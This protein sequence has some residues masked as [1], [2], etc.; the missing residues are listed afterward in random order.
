MAIDADLLRHSVTASDAGDYRSGGFSFVL[1]F[2][3]P[4]NVGGLPPEPPPYWSFQR[5]A[6]LRATILKEAFWSSAVTIAAT[7][8]ATAGFDLDGPER[9]TR[10][11]QEMILEWSGSGEGY[12]PSQQRAV[13]DYLTTGNGT[14]FEIVR[15]S[16]AAGSKIIG[17]ITL[18]SLRC[19]RT[20]DP[21]VPILYRDLKGN[22]HEM[23]DYQVVSI[24]DQPDS[25][26]AWFGVGHCAAERAYTH[27]YRMAA[28]EQYIAE[29]I[30]GSGATKIALVQG[31]S[32]LQIDN[33]TTT[34][35]AQKSSKGLTYY[36]G[37]IIAGIL[38]DTPIDIKEIALR[39]LPDGFN[40]KEE[41]DI[42]LLAYADA[43]GLDPQDLQPLSGQ[44]LGTG[45][46]TR[47]LH[48]KAKGRWPARYNKQFA[49]LL[50]MWVT[51]DSVTF[52]FS[53][54]DLDDDK[55][56]V[57]NAATRAGTLEKYINAGVINP[58]QALQIAVDADDVPKEFLPQDV[59]P[60]E[61][62]SDVEKPAIDSVTDGTEVPV[63]E[64]PAP[65]A[66]PM[67]L[68]SLDA[69]Y[70]LYQQM[71][72]ELG[73]ASSQNGETIKAVTEPE[74]VS[75]VNVSVTMPSITLSP[76]MAFNLPEQKAMESNI[77]FEPQH[78]TVNIPPQQSLDVSS[79]ADALR[80]QQPP[81]INNTIQV[82]ALDTTPIADA[83]RD[84]K[85][86]SV[87]VEGANITV[88]VPPPKPVTRRVVRDRDGLISEVIEEMN[89]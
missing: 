74:P 71:R 17:L 82:A 9:Q 16:S 85:P 58:S 5:D 40:R 44:G 21:D 72:K 51:P 52:S 50:N 48:E 36:M 47:V 28:I 23:R 78:I 69:G 39:G 81:I 89:G 75:P 43:I 3:F 7:K 63:I 41:L 24:V 56:E 76:Q 11:Y 87:T 53:E 83:L 15:V 65:E 49:A 35:E 18:D 80:A 1:P 2:F 88:E 73:G 68:K 54:R 37:A 25:G 27:I 8:V 34:A 45:T 84:Q 20:G 64:I 13:G 46:Q 57:D 10:K 55:K 61:S 26:A 86:P 33:L 12:V 60:D 6:I 14:H 67:A 29:K 38:G 30:T 66:P 22:L 32:T 19:Q 77:S 62:L 4:A 42:A 59:T 79:I 31:M 70:A